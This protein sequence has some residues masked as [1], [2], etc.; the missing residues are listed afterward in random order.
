MISVEDG[1]CPMERFYDN[2]KV[3]VFIDEEAA[4]AY[5]EV[6]QGATE[7]AVRRAVELVS[8]YGLYPMDPTGTSPRGRYGFETESGPV[9][10][11]YCV[12]LN[13]GTV[14]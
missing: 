13:F 2:G 11:H 1:G 4:E 5:V 8:N 7:W 14:G 12:P 3:H 6:R 9:R 10:R